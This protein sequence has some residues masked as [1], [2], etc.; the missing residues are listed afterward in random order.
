MIKKFISVFSIVI[1]LAMILGCSD[2]GT[3][4]NEPGYDI[5]RANEAVFDHTHLIPDE[6]ALSMFTPL[7]SNPSIFYA[8]YSPPDRENYGQGRQ[9]PVLFLLAPFGE[10][11]LYYY[12]RGL[13][14]VA[15]KM[16]AEGEIEPMIIICINNAFGYG[17]TFYGNS[18]GGGKYAKAI[19]DIEGDG[20]IGTLLDYVN[21]VYNV[22]TL[23][24]SP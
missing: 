16:I 4:I 2:R 9:F 24:A 20:E 22:D 13:V 5:R 21:D 7:R 3:N 1:I 23:S 12:S 18:W 19:G 17:G 6:L 10:N 11:Q 8:V 14:A 15:D